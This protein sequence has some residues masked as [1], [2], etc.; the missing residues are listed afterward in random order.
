[1]SKFYSGDNIDVEN[2]IGVYIKVLNDNGEYIPTFFLSL[3]DR[4]FEIE[5]FQVLINGLNEAKYKIE[6]LIEIFENGQ[7][8]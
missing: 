2:G 3:P 8:S 6:Q 5:E 4:D 1:M 7:D